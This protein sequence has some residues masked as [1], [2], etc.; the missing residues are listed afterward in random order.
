MVTIDDIDS[1]I[2]VRLQSDLVVLGDSIMTDRHHASNGNYEDDDPQNQIGGII[3]A[4]PLSGWLRH[5]MEEVVIQY[6]GTAC[7]PGEANANFMKDDIYERDLDDGYH[8]STLADRPKAII[9]GSIGMWSPAIGRT[10]ANLC[11]TSSSMQL[12]IS[13]GVGTSPSGRRNPSSSACWPKPST[14]STHTGPTSCTNSVA[15]GTSVPG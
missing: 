1:D 4:F 6:G 7:H 12:R 15:L 5:G 8:E 13:T 2:Y 11:G 9:D 3:P 10:V 14:S